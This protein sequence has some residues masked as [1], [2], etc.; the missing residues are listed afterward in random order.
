MSDDNARMFHA[1]LRPFPICVAGRPAANIFAKIGGIT[2]LASCH[3]E[4]REDRGGMISLGADV[5]CPGFA[6]PPPGYHYPRS[7][8]AFS[9]L[10]LLGNN[11]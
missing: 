11:R 8:Y 9:C 6:Q 3:L 5:D 1:P 10:A 7:P 2:G 4:G